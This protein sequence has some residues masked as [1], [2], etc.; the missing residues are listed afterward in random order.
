VN[1]DLLRYY[2]QELLHLRE[3][4]G[5]FAAA[6]PKIA[7]RLGLE[8]F[9]C[10]DP[11][12]ERLLEGFSFLAARIQ[13]KLDARFPMFARHL[14][15]QV[16][17]HFLAPTPSMAVVR[18]EPDRSHSALAKGVVVPR[19]TALYSHLD[20]RGI[21][22][23]EYRTAHEVTLWPLRLLDADYKPYGGFPSMAASGSRASAQAVLRLRLERQDGKP[24]NALD[25]ADLPIYLHGSDSAPVQL[26]EQLMGHVTAA[27]VVPAEGGA[28]W[29]DRLPTPCVS[30]LGFDDD[31]AMLPLSARAFRGYRLLHEYFAFP[32]RFRFIRIEGLRE[33]LRKCTAARFDIVFL[34]DEHHVQLERTVS[35]ARFML[36]C[37]PAINLFPWR[38]DRIA[39][40]DTSFEHHVVPDRTRPLDFEVYGVRAVRG[41]RGADADPCHFLPLYSSRDPAT[42]GF[43]QGGHFQVRRET[44][45]LSERERRHGA[46]SRYLGSEAYI[47]LVEGEQDGKEAG[48]RQIGL[49]LLCTNRDLP[50]SMPLGAGRTDFSF[51]ADFPVAEVRCVSGPTE[52][53]PAL[54]DDAAV[55]RFLN[56]LSLNYLPLA[57][58]ARDGDNERA[59]R[60]L[61]EL[62][63]PLGDAAMRRKIT[64]VVGLASRPVTRRLPYPG[65][66]CFGRG[67]EVAVTLDDAAFEGDG[68]FMLGAVLQAFFASY[69]SMNHFTETVVRTTSRG[70]I[71]RWPAREGLCHIL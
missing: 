70:E 55:W 48:L 30:A 7:G 51:G 61:L 46:R 35:A 25:I 44:R 54:A 2:N 16:Y 31:Q 10:A 32:A 39:V 14:A 20:Q 36:Y 33:A 68:A 59:L 8:S 37:T 57:D 67:I 69:V 3:M 50:L 22:R 6:F 21:T 1:P 56:H 42:D 52:P 66:I 28:A 64:G 65:P 38:A 53:R 49:D 18:L 26:Y 12:V 43:V 13:M 40:D 60:E 45:L 63:R 4:G 9:E 5:E 71:M 17:P 23:C 41:Y 11:Y 62:Y 47:A 29:S 58:G 34:L 27:M 19:Q 15:E 24:A